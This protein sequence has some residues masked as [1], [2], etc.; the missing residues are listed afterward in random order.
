MTLLRGASVL[1]LST[2]LFACPRLPPLDYGKDGPAKDGADLLKRIEFADAQ[3][4]SVKGDAKLIVESPQGKGSVSLFIA[5]LHPAQ[6]HIEQLDFFG[7]PEGVLVTDGERFGL[8]DAKQRKYFRGPASVENMAR[9]VPIALPPRELAS[10]LLGR[11]PR[12]PPESTELTI[13]EPTRTYGLSLKRGAITQ[14]LNVSTGTHRVTKSRVE[15][16]NTYAIDTDDLA[17]YG[18]ATL[19]RHLTLDAPSAK[20]KVELL[21]KDIVVN[22]A[23]EVTMFEIEP[24]E[25]IPVVEVQA[26]GQAV[27]VP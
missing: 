12:V 5:V 1:L 22:E 7:R 25:G 14:R 19:P 26:N 13:D 20:T 15:G 3:I 10:L 24:P 4:F 6:L 18:A 17:V 8:Y 27:P 2:A 9:F 21:Y 11:V 16:L 23:P